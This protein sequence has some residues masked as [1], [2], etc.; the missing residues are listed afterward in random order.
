M[1][2]EPA[3]VDLKAQHRELRHRFREP[4]NSM[5]QPQESVKEFTK[6][7]KECLKEQALE[8]HKVD[9]RERLKDIREY[10]RERTADPMEPHNGSE[11]EEEIQKEKTLGQ[12]RQHSAEPLVKPSSESFREC[13][14][15]EARADSFPAIAAENW[16]SSMDP[17]RF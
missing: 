16:R 3:T 14:S 9:H 5:R 13:R 6:D 10:L 1:R 4:G 8:Q 12:Q 2:L 17:F 15:L 11:L 7:T